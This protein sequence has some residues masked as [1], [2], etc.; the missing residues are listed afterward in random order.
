MIAARIAFCLA[1]V[2]TM[3]TPVLTFMPKLDLVGEISVAARYGR[4]AL[5]PGLHSGFCHS[6]S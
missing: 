6:D 3:I 4:L 2:M 5:T 1:M